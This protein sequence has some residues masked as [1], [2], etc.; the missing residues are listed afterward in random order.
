MGLL[1]CILR[2]LTSSLLL[3]DVIVNGRINLDIA[4]VS[5]DVVVEM[6]VEGMEIE[7]ETE[8]ETGGI[9]PE[10]ELKNFNQY[11][12]LLLWTESVLG[13]TMALISVTT[14]LPALTDNGVISSIATVL[15]HKPLRTN[16]H[17]LNSLID[18]VERDRI[19]IIRLHID[20][21]VVQILDTAITNHSGSF[22]AFKDQGGAEAALLRLLDELEILSS[23]RS[24]SPTSCSAS[25]SIS[26]SS[27]NLSVTLSATVGMEIG[28]ESIGEKEKDKEDEGRDEIEI[29]AR[30]DGEIDD[31]DSSKENGAVEIQQVETA[32]ASP[33]ILNISSLEA[34][35]AVSE[36]GKSKIL[37]LPPG[38]K[39]LLHQLISLIISWVQ[40]TQQDSSDH[41]HGQLLKGS[42]FA[43]IFGV[44]FNNVTILS[45]ALI[46]PAVALIADIINNDPA[47]PG[48]LSHMLSSGVIELSLRACLDPTLVFN[49][50][51]LMSISSLISACCLTQE[52]IDLVKSINPFPHLFS[53]LLDEK[54]YYPHSKT[55]MTDLPNN[56]GS[57]LEELIRHYPTLQS[58]ILNS[59]LSKLSDVAALAL[60]TKHICSPAQITLESSS[61][62]SSLLSDDSEKKVR[63]YMTSCR[64][65]TLLYFI[66]FLLFILILLRHLLPIVGAAC[67]YDISSE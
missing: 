16:K 11:M 40:D 21:L 37:S 24:D 42:L 34:M 50:D 29:I 62:T 13:L 3:E 66:I 54:Y 22:V 47:P 2:S 60:G 31:V 49:N 8:T 27:V 33:A 58:I 23:E 26:S 14:A 44:L 67:R 64:N 19:T 30:K 25:A 52:G 41:L 48:L 56:F 4:A 46:S 18:A 38:N 17:P 53:L 15:S 59:L 36:G 51:L 39:V 32:S 12:E 55:F 45:S 1:P 6:D 20:S 61:S 43:Q 5:S 28:L 10:L 57:S 9:S 63:E 7:T 35:A 65:S